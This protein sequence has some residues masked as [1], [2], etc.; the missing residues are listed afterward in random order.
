MGLIGPT[1]FKN[2]SLENMNIEY[3]VSPKHLVCKKNIES[4]QGDNVFRTVKK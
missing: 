3:F 1:L 4:F 2:L